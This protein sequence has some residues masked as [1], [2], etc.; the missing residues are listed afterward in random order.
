[1]LKKIHQYKSMNYEKI[2]IEEK[3]YRLLQSY[4][5]RKIQTANSCK[6]QREIYMDRIKDSRT[7]RKA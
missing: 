1:M 2:K 7:N 6:W 4:F 3:K 5:Y